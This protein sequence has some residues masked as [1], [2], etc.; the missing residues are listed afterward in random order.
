M[1]QLAKSKRRRAAGIEKIGDMWTGMC[2]QETQ[3][4]TKLVPSAIV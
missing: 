2:A 3:S 4:D 1:I